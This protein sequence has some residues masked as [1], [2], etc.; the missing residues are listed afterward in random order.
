MFLQPLEAEK[1]IVRQL[2]VQTPITVPRTSTCTNVHEII[3]NLSLLLFLN[4]HVLEFVIRSG[5]I[6][7]RNEQTIVPCIKRAP[8]VRFVPFLFY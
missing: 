5:I 1:N 7:L 2:N 4:N 3:D 6:Q 8:S